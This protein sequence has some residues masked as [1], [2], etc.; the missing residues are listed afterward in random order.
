M[1]ISAA[2]QFEVSLVGNMIYSNPKGVFADFTQGNYDKQGTIE[3]RNNLIYGN[4]NSG[5]QIKGGAES[6]Y[7]GE[8]YSHQLINNTLYLNR[9]INF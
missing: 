9:F 1:G 4:T 8:H 3:L 7:G 5:V 2:T 6:P